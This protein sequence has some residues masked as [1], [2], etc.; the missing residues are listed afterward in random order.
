MMRYRGSLLVLG[1]FIL[2]PAFACARTVVIGG[3]Y[4]ETSVGHFGCTC[5]REALCVSENLVFEAQRRGL[6]VRF[7][8]IAQSYEPLSILTAA[9]TI[10]RLNYDVAIGANLSSD[11]ILA[12]NVFEKARIPF[13]PPTAT[14][15]KV[16]EGKHF[17]IR[18]AF[19][20]RR[21][22]VNLAR[23]AADESKD[24]P[25]AVVRNVSQPYSDF[26]GREFI[27]EV[28]RLRPKLA[29]REFKIIDGGPDFQKLVKEVVSEKP[30]LIFAPLFRSELTLIYEELARSESASTLLTSDTI[31]AEP[32]FPKS[33]KFVP[34]F[35]FTRHWNHE[36]KGQAGDRYREFHRRYCSHLPVSMT[37]VAAYDAMSV[38]LDTLAKKPSV[39]RRTLA[40][41]VRD[42]RFPGVLGETVRDAHGDPEKPIYLYEL[43]R[44]GA[45]LSQV[46]Q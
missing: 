42:N 10:A 9:Q 30:R 25:V 33:S 12:A 6:D 15:P 45:V 36:L 37:S 35:L 5:N 17:A 20:D 41:A 23:F 46:M 19:S 34:K 40:D 31:E 2:A 7:Q 26:L 24:G 16:T 28:R 43:K 44:E 18:M 4:A 1:C 38:L 14:N 22:A 11:A 27:A 32:H 21:Q 8:N 39:R 13:I 29:I 3:L